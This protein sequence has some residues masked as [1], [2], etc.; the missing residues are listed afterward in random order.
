[1]YIHVMYMYMCTYTIYMYTYSTPFLHHLV[2]G[3]LKTE[4]FTGSLTDILKLL[5]MGF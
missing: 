2:H 3:F 1:M 5:Q 4:F